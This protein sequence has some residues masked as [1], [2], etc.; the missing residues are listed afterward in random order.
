M[1]QPL[2][3]PNVGGLFAAM[4]MPGS[5]SAEQDGDGDGDGAEFR[6]WT[7]AHPNALESLADVTQRIGLGKRRI[8][9]FLDY[10]GTLAHIVRN[11]EEVGNG[12]R[13]RERTCREL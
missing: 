8:G 1:S 12:E 13:E 7:A 2:G 5:A 10:D 4:M 3:V 9:V 6:R 11:P